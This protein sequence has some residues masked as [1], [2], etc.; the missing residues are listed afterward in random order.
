MS[1]ALPVVWANYGLNRKLL[2]P[3]TE[4]TVPCG[5]GVSRGGGGHILWG[6]FTQ[7]FKWV[8]PVKMKNEKI[9]LSD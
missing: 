2:S 3:P 4:A 5:Q 7:S 1:L 8:I 9:Y 6:Q